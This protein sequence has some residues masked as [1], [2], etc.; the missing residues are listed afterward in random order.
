MANWTD[1]RFTATLHGATRKNNSRNGNPMWKLHTSE[2]DYLTGTDSAIGYE[3][4]N[5]TG[6]PGNWVG[7]Q[8][9]FTATEKGRVYAWQLA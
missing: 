5:H 4:S 3:V 7:R 1:R 6:G 2:G 9:K 8:V